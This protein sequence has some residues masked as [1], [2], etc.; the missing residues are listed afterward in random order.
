MFDPFYPFD[1]LATQLVTRILGLSLDSSLGSSLHF[2]FYDVPK[3]LTL[4]LTISFIVGTLQSFLEP[5]K[6]R[7]FLAGKF[8][9]L[10]N[11]LAGCIGVI[12]P[13]CSCSAVPLFIGFLEAGVPLGVTFSYLISAPMVNEVAVIL[14]WGLFGLRV[15]LLYISF[16]LILAIIAGYSIGKLKL[17]KWVEPF[18]WE[19]QKSYQPRDEDEEISLTWK[20]RWQQGQ[21]QASEIFK[22]VWLYVVIGIAIGAVIHGYVPADFIANWAGKNNPFAVPL[23]VVMGVPLYANIAGVLPI[24]EA[25]V[26]KG[27]PL[28][29]VLAFTM[30]VTALSLPEMIILRKVLKMPLLTVFISLVTVG[31]IGVGYLF[32]LL[33]I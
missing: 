8:S 20:Q 2:F 13:F 26:S 32:N 14:L 29:T 15:T 19:L 3:V 24:T 33:G 9:F 17:E 10:G 28:G 6:V 18:V 12:T 25:L 21:Y 23:A 16:G 5:S 4:L 27:I 22:S 7:D 1:W 30:A 11:I 31:I